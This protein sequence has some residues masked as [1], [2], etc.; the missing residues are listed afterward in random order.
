MCETRVLAL[1]ETTTLPNNLPASSFRAVPPEGR[2]W[3][4]AAARIRELDQQVITSPDSAR[5]AESALGWDETAGLLN[6]LYVDWILVERRP[7]LDVDSGRGMCDRK[8]QR[9]V[10]HGEAG[11]CKGLSAAPPWVAEPATAPVSSAKLVSVTDDSNAEQPHT[12]TTMEDVTAGS[13]KL[14]ALVAEPPPTS[15]PPVSPVL[16]CGSRNSLSSETSFL[17]LTSGATLES[18][19]LMPAVA[20]S[21]MA[22]AVEQLPSLSDQP[23]LV[24]P[25]PAHA[26][27]A[28]VCV[29]IH[30]GPT[31]AWACEAG[32]H[33]S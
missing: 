16:G 11:A 29:W 26:P 21:V 25:V 9:S 17:D 13:V 30:G 32:V 5:A 20:H 4:C 6:L 18:P 33:M 24:V 2:R 22:A 31:C 12:T 1:R 3:P 28:K 14:G 19:A 27:T 15:E 8:R 23:R 7:A 10:D